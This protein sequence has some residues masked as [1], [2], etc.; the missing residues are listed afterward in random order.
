MHFLHAGRI[1]SKPLAKNVPDTILQA[2]DEK[3]VL[4]IDRTA[5]DILNLSPLIDIQKNDNT[6]GTDALFKRFFYKIAQGENYA[7]FPFAK[8]SILF[9]QMD[10]PL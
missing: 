1:T 7:M 10:I 5:C 8:C 2:V 3:S 4:I 6:Q 9:Q